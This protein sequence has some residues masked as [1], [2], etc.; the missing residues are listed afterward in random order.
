MNCWFCRSKLVW[1]GDFSFEDYGIE[2]EGLVANL[3]CT[4]DDCGAYFEG[5]VNLGERS[6]D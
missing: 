1:H 4:N 3:Y 5:F 6:D 2:G